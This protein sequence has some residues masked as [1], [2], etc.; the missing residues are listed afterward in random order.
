MQ[1]SAARL[2]DR[3]KNDRKKSV[4]KVVEIKNFGIELNH[5]V[6]NDN[7]KWNWVDDDP[8]HRAFEIADQLANRGIDNI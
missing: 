6:S 7:L 1:S 2:S 5:A 4:Q 8:G 3:K